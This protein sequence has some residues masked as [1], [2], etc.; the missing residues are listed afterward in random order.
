MFGIPVMKTELFPHILSLQ[1]IVQ[2]PRRVAITQHQFRVYKSTRRTSFTD[3]LG[4]REVI[5]AD[6]E[7]VVYVRIPSDMYPSFSVLFSGIGYLGQTSSFACCIHVDR[8][9]PP[10]SGS[11]AV[12]VRHLNPNRSLE[13][14]YTAPVTE[15]REE[16]LEWSDLMPDKEVADWSILRHTQYVWPM[17]KTASS[18]KDCLYSFSPFPV[19]AHAFLE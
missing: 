5:H 6:G 2:P 8:D 1:P 15:L 18:G 9:S 3:S 11:Y 13:A 14:Y 4:H 19:D 12:P 10:Q 17:I 16:G 7:I